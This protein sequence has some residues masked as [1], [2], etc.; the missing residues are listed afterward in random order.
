[1]LNNYYQYQVT[2]MNKT[3]WLNTINK[4]N[5]ADSQCPNIILVV[6]HLHEI[7]IQIPVQCSTK[8]NLPKNWTLQEMRHTAFSLKEFLVSLKFRYQTKTQQE[9]SWLSTKQVFLNFEA[10]SHYFLN[11]KR[12]VQ[13][14]DLN[15]RSGIN[16]SWISKFRISSITF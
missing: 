16:E 2:N 10:F 9:C 5:S 6:S 3:L 8:L 11:L 4:I 13:S 15:F 1:M 14:R 12:I 7:C